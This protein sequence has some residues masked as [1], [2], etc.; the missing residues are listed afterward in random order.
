VEFH[1]EIEA[2]IQS[3][4][5]LLKD[6]KHDVQSVAAFT[7][8]KLAEHGELQLEIVTPKLMGI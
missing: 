5:V 7:L 8:A 4:I 2:A 6:K 3:L 1:D